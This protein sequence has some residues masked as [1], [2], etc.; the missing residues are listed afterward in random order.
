MLGNN[1]FIKKKNTVLT[2]LVALLLPIVCIVLLLTQT[3]FAKN[4]Y[5][6]NDGGRIVIHTTYAT[7][8][9]DVLDEAGLELG[10][11][12][13][14]TT[15]LG[16]GM[17]EITIQRM[18]VVNVVYGGNTLT[19]TTYGETVEALLNRMNFKLTEDDVLSETL[20]A[21]TYDGMTL[22][23][24]RSVSTEETYTV[25]IPFETE[26]CYDASLAEGEQ[27]I[28]TQGVEG[29][30]Q[31]KA[32]VHYIDGQ[33][34]SRSLISEKV[35][36]Q[37]VNA[38]I[39]IGTGVEMPDY[40]PESMPTEPPTQA[41]TKPAPTPEAP[42]VEKMPIIGENTITTPEGEVLTYTKAE[43][44]VATAYHNSDPGCTIWT[45]TGTLCRVGAIAV[46][47]KVIPYGTRMYIVTNDGKYIY[48]IATAEDCGSSIK[49]N[50]V[51]LYYNSVAECNR[52]GIRD[53]TIYFLG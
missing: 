25:A 28:L 9:A 23:I 21:M 27:V 24:A 46:D 3:A 26:Y 37:P 30:L 31:C 29:Q 33:E 48:G 22:T 15:Q 50:R 38:L 45:S 5:L 18:Q 8:P 42:P 36:S 51:D 43:Q 32:S 2:R 53:C 1:F 19:V 44:F 4:T 49:G 41:P 47:P 7:D 39:A 40:P 14:Y 11:N 52:F 34:V 35:I 12:D 17:S 16:L 20:S 13:T 10:M 6:I